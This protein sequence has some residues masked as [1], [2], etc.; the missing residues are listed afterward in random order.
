MNYKIKEKNKKFKIIIIDLSLA[1]KYFDILSFEGSN[2]VY[3]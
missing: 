2:L 1:F 3:R